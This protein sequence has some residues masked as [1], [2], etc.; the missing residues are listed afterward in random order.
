MGGGDAG[1]EGLTAEEGRGVGFYDG[2]EVLHDGAIVE[3][4]NDL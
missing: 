3:E 2:V 4:G 1:H